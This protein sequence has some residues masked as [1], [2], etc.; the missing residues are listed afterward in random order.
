MKKIN[1]KVE[2]R[3]ILEIGSGQG[4]NCHYL[5]RNKENIVIGIDLS[6]KDIA[7]SK[8]RYPG[9]DFRYMNA[10][11]LT[12]AK[13]TFDEIYAMDIL[14]HVDNLEKVLKE[15][16]RVLKIGGKMVVNIPY[17]KSE[18]WLLKVRPTF[19]KEIHHVRIFSENELEI[20]FKKLGLKKKLK[21]KVDFLQHI[22]LYALFKR[23]IKSQTQISIG[24]WR[25]NFF[26]IFVHVAVLYF[27]PAI[28]KTPL[29]YLPIWVITLPVGFII[30]YF[31][32]KVF[33]RSV[34]YEFIK[35]K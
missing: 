35:Q 19:H 34:Y 25:D 1:S 2:N 6:K 13:N 33:P 23:N 5:S 3:N 21:K 27:S 30:N 11:K 22:E 17:H 9:V 4:F 29:I 18:K 15:V 16:K 14:E 31:G 28:L 24:S 12:F 32:N 26:T 10:E 20:R 7:I 8:K